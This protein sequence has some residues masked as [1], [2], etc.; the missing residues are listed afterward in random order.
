LRIYLDANV[1]VA[2]LLNESTTPRVRTFV[3]DNAGRLITS[4]FAT[5]E[6]VSAIG[7]SIRTRSL[8]PEKGEAVIEFLDE[9]VFAFASVFGVDSGDI[10]AAKEILHDWSLGLR[11]PDAINIAIA[12]RLGAEL[13]TFDTRMAAAAR[14]VGLKIAKL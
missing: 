13:A 8:T 7:R 2:A 3:G 11:A 9:W 1:L 5:A 14:K 10:G 4:D 6:T 12:Q